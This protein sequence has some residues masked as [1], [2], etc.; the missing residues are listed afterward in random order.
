LAHD[1]FISYSSKDKVVADAV[2]ARLESRGVR[3]WI[4]PRDVPSGTRYGAA[5]IKAINTS[6]LMVLI[7]S[8]N[9]NASEHIPNE[10]ERGVSR[11]LPILPFRIE[12]VRPAESFELFIGSVHWLDALTKP[13]EQHLDR[14]AESVLQLLPDRPAHAPTAPIPLPMGRSLLVWQIVVAVAATLIVISGVWLLKTGDARA[15]NFGSFTARDNA[16]EI[17]GCWQWGSRPPMAIRK[18]GTMAAGR[19]SGNWWR[20][21]ARS[22]ELV[23][24][25]RV[26]M[27]SMTADKGSVSASDRYGA[28]TSLTRINIPGLPG[29]PATDGMAGVWQVNG[30]TVVF[31]V[32]GLI[33][34][35]SLEGSWRL[36][37]GPERL[38]EVTW[39]TLEDTAKATL[40]SD[41]SRIEGTNRQGVAV[42]AVRVP[43]CE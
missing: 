42:S 20:I 5:I 7:L 35:G 12:D 43:V 17:A 25:T 4:A 39:P 27:L 3:C 37:D 22:Y 30:S 38:Y 13:L 16:P 41:L 19:F 40:S 23:W 8:S 33:R 1:V 18:D 11:G 24:P 31:N 15:I 29:I 6:R 36:A 34:D 14:L 2:C 21:D 9:A 28:A 32:N 10:I 26:V